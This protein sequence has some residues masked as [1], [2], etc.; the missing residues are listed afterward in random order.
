MMTWHSDFSDASFCVQYF[1]NSGPRTSAILVYS[2]VHS[3]FFFVSH[4]T[5]HTRG[6]AAN[7][8]AHHLHQTGVRREHIT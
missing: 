4:S 6:R 8:T 5:A 7:F 2:Q 1:R 3:L